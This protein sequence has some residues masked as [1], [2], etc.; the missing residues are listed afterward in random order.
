MKVLKTRVIKAFVDLENVSPHSVQDFTHRHHLVPADVLV[1]TRVSAFISQFRQLGFS[2]INNYPKGKNGADF[3][4]LAE[5]VKNLMQTDDERSTRYL[6]S[7][8]KALQLAFS[9]QCHLFGTEGIPYETSENTRRY[10]RSG[11]T[12]SMKRVQHHKLDADESLVYE[13]IS[14][15]SSNKMPISN[16]AIK[17]ETSLET[18]RFC[19]AIMA[20]QSKKLIVKLKSNAQLYS[21]YCQTSLTP[22]LSELELRGIAVLTEPLTTN[23]WRARLGVSK[24]SFNIMLA[25]L[26][27][28]HRVVR[29][30]RRR[31]Q[32]AS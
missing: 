18:H 13:V 11:W 23:Q 6:L 29:T 20:L 9:H 24:Q 7:N 16:K 30:K 31:F 32:I 15:H 27:S 14:K 4:I 28:K 1:F 12:V 19:E 2:V 5:L 3:C 21:K 8:D 26:T 10:R 22:P 17:R 25:G